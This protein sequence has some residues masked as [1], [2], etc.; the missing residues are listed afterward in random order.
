MAFYELPSTIVVRSQHV[1]S[2]QRA[3]NERMDDN[4]KEYSI[5]H[6]CTLWKGTILLH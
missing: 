1:V 5:F 3:V 4:E 2:A 6:A